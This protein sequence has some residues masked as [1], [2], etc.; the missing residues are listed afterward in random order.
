MN[1]S[2]K[3]LDDTCQVN[4]LTFGRFGDP[5]DDF[6]GAMGEAT[7]KVAVSGLVTPQPNGK[8]VITIDELGFYLRDAYDFN[9]DS[10]VSQPLGF[11]G[12]K[13]VERFHLG[14]DVLMDEQWVYDEADSARASYYLV[15][16]AHFRKWRAHHGLGGD[17]M[18]LSDVHRVRLPFPIQLEW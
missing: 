12:F 13:G 5:M 1:Q 2:A 15:Q 16:N 18:V 4:F 11:W 9:D 3:Q 6:Y 7:L 17:F 10:F 8:T 14:R